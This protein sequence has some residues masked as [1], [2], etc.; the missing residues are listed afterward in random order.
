MEGIESTTL[1]CPACGDEYVAGSQFCSDCRV[2]LVPGRPDTATSSTEAPTGLPAGYV[3]L[4]AWPPMATVMLLR[5][6]TDASVD[7]STLWSDPRRGGMTVI[8]VPENQVEFADAVLRELPIEDELPQGNASSHLDRIEA[9]LTE[10]AML[11]DEL[12]QLEAEER[13]QGLS[14]P[15]ERENRGPGPW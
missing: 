4:G 6:L 13:G 11:L 9:R 10:V 14:G 1:F 5:R 2:A 8:A 12:R 7:V 3:E 15:G